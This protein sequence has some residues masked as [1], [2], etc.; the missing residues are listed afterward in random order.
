[1]E[2]ALS[3]GSVDDVVLGKAASSQLVNG[4]TTRTDKNY[5]IITL[6]KSKFSARAEVRGSIKDDN[7]FHN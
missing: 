3:Y 7:T 2:G 6:R 4:L 1:M 5:Q